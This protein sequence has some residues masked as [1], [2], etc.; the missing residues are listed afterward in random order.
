VLRLGREGRGG[1][2]GIEAEEGGAGKEVGVGDGMKLSAV[3]GLRTI[4]S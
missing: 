2:D 1:D 4:H 3:S